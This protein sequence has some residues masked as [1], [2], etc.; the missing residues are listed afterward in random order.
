MEMT[1]DVLELS[2][3]HANVD[4]SYDTSNFTLTLTAKNNYTIAEM[5][6]ALNAVK[7]KNTTDEPYE[8]S[9]NC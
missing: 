3:S 5:R 6:A 2:G 9:E 1:G 4:A 8:G 7:Y